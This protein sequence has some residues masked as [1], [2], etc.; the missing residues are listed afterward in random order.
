LEEEELEATSNRD[1]ERKLYG[2]KLGR[3]I[4]TK[5]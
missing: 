4:K 2:L 3:K 5:N 1:M